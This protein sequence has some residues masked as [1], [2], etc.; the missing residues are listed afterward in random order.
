M[1]EISQIG[2]CAGCM[3]SKEIRNDRGGVFM[4]C[5]RSFREPEY[6]KYPR[7]PVVRCA[8]FEEKRDQTRI[9]PFGKGIS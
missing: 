6:P 3:R 1:S 4:M 7:L 8:G 9:D 2:L 5:L